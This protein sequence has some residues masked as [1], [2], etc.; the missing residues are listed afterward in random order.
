MTKK[1]SRT[2]I[3]LIILTICLAIYYRFFSPLWQQKRMVLSVGI[4]NSTDTVELWEEPLMSPIPIVTEYETR[5]V[6][7]FSTGKEDWHVI[8]PEYIQFRKVAVLISTDSSKIRV[9][10]TGIS[11]PSHMIAEYDLR[12]QTFRAEDEFSVIGK[13]GWVLLKEKKVR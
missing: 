12:N 11:T 4:P 6:I 2:I 1:L 10:T 7:R 3:I 9:E 5:F 8:D 13:E